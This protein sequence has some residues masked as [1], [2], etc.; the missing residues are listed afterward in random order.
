MVGSS[1]GL[2]NIDNKRMFVGANYAWFSG[3]I[4]KDLSDSQWMGA[5]MY[6]ESGTDWQTRDYSLPR[7][8]PYYGSLISWDTELFNYH[9]QRLEGKVDA[10][11]VWVAEELEGML[12]T[13]QGDGSNLVTGIYSELTTSFQ[14]LLDTCAK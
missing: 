5:E 14:S 4:G 12:F 2:A 7:T 13:H 1:G 9:L 3:W 10:I 8:L 6:P 11:R